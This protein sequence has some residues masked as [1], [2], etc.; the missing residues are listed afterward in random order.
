MRFIR[1]FACAMTL[2]LLGAC[3]GGSGSPA[4]VLALS[5]SI[6]GS[7]AAA[8]AS[9]QYVVRPG[10]R[11]A[12]TPSTSA[13]WTSSGDT[14]VVQLREASVSPSQWTAQILNARTTASTYSVTAQAIA[15][16]ALTQAV[17]FQ[18]A[19]GDAR[20]GNYDVYA[21][22]G[23]SFVLS[24]N[25]DANTYSFAYASGAFAA[26][27]VFTADSS[28]PGTF[29]FTTGRTLIGLAPRFRMT[30]DA[31]VGTFPFG[32][33]AELTRTGGPSNSPFI[34]VRNL[35][36]QQAQI[37]GLYNRLSL[38]R[39]LVE[40]TAKVMQM[41]ISGSGTVL[42][43]CASA[44]MESVANC[45]AGSVITYAIAPSETPGI[46]TAVNNA[47]SSDQLRFAMARIGDR[48]VYLSAGSAPTAPSAP[49]PLLGTWAW[50]LGVQDTPTWLPGTGHGCDAACGRIDFTATGFTRIVVNDQGAT[51]GTTSETYL[52][53]GAAG[54]AGVRRISDS[55]SRNNYFAVYDT[56]LLVIMGDQAT[57]TTSDYV[58]LNL[59]D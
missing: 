27:G 53:M 30:T 24:L 16:P 47:D 15:N 37:D 9:G 33:P 49:R 36:A 8:D 56:R 14:T 25:F 11:V 41:Q 45:P 7:L 3:G 23:Q 6:N 40:H 51:V 55:N 10:D 29:V 5:V 19:A 28:E 46:W 54:P 39:S 42:E 22:V 57:F 58:Q 52:P 2:A 31:V 4:P 26:S 13:S 1:S 50:Q 59:V 12:I 18:V 43:L 32:D 48:K 17:V 34:G 44:T 35:V 21:A 20:N 38:R